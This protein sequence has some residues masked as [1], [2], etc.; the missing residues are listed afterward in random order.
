MQESAEPFASLG[1]ED[2]MGRVWS[3]GFGLERGESSLVKIGN[4]VPN[5]LLMAAD[6]TRNCWRCLSLSAGDQH[7]AA[8]DGKAFC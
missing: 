4:R 2:L 5:R 8:P 6:Q 3:R 7:V 1:I